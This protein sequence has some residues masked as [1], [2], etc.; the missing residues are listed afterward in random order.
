MG[1]AKCGDCLYFGCCSKYVDP[2]ETFPEIGGCHRFENKAEYVK[3]VRCKDC[4]SGRVRPYSDD[5][6]YCRVMGCAFKAE[7]FCSY[8]ERREGE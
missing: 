7:H 3:V 8:G 2:E 5:V 1:M 6:I 4:K